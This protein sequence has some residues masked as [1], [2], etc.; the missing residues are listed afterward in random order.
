MTP[1]GAKALARGN[2]GAIPRKILFIV[3]E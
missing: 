1:N 3:R 2:N